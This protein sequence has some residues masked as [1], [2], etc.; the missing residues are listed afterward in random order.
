MGWRHNKACCVLCKTDFDISNMGILPVALSETDKNV[1][2]TI[3]IRRLIAAAL[4]S[5]NCDQW[6]LVA[7]H[8]HMLSYRYF[9]HCLLHCALAATQCI[10]V[11]PFCLFVGGWVCY[12]DNTTMRASILTKLGLLVKV[13]LIKF[14]LSHA[15]GKWVCGGVKKFGSA[16]LQPAC[17]VCV[18]SECLFIFPALPGLR[19]ARFTDKVATNLENMEKSGNLKVIRESQW[20]CVLACDVLP[21]VVR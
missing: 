21:R 8:S 19:A 6:A 17:S 5:C 18:S 20:K 4:L 10:I 9:I 2:S 15:P 1:I 16:L 13:V 11:G 12:H 14:W 7:A 3:G